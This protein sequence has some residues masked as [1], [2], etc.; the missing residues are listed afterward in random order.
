MNKLLFS[1]CFF[2]CIFNAASSEGGVKKK[3]LFIGNSY[4]FTNNMP[5][6]L[7]SIAAAMGDTLQHDMSAPGGYTLN[8]HTTN[9][10]TIG[11]IFAQQ[12]DV[13]VIHEQSQM[14]AFPPA[15]VATDVYPY[16]TR[17]DSMVKANDTCT[18]TMFM[19]TW[20]HANG[21]PGNCPFYP[22]IC[23]YT[24]QQLRLRESYLQMGQDNHACVAPVG[25]AYKVMMDSTYT[26]WLFSGDSSH[27]VIA[28]SYLEACVLYSSIYHKSTLNCTFTNGMPAADARLLQRIAT[29]VVF[30]SL[31][32]WQ[33]YGHYPY[34]GFTTTSSGPS[35]SFTQH[36]PVTTH[37]S[38]LFGDGGSD[39][40]ANPAHLY[41]AS[42]T[43]TV[44]HTV[45][46]G[47]FSETKTDT[48]VVLPTSVST[49]S[50]NGNTVL[51]ASGSG[52]YFELW[53]ADSQ[54]FSAAI[55][56]MQGRVVR[57][58]QSGTKIADKLEAGIYMV[59]ITDAKNEVCV[60]K[61][62]VH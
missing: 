59:R 38:W 14:P 48:V 46:N 28:G 20:G 10:T 56:D 32:Q 12:W 23:T 25:M 16:A 31:N 36:S 44:T 35:R 3:V 39:T 19:M 27:P 51:S 29:K 45:S 1:L 22:V 21:D 55:F 9:T 33:G 58:Y 49:I 47:C 24:G 15:Q 40:A 54:P 52:G 6:M 7:D 30:D 42:G 8:Q 17:L 50:H 4:T 11:K 41:T 60:T 62:A 53:L 26:P 13:T 57:N 2:S 5:D 43:Y 61:I 37:H 18:Q 34:A